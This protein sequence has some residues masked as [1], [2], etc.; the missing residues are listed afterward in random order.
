MHIDIERVKDLE[1]IVGRIK[2]LSDCVSIAEEADLVQDERLWMKVRLEK[3][4]P[5]LCEEKCDSCIRSYD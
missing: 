4:F 1:I 3:K 2:R 5:L